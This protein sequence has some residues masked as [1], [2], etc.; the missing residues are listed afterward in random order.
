[1]SKQNTLIIRI[2]DQKTIDRVVHQILRP[3]LMEIFES[4]NTLDGSLLYQRTIEMDEDDH[5]IIYIG[6]EVVLDYREYESSTHSYLLKVKWLQ[7]KHTEEPPFD[8]YLIQTVLA[9]VVSACTTQ[10]SDTPNI[11]VGD[12]QRLMV[13]QELMEAQFGSDGYTPSQNGERAVVKVGDKTGHVDLNTLK[14]LECDSSLL[15]GRLEG[16]LRVAEQLARPLIG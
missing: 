3:R 16:V 1:M 5:R 7:Q 6:N 2:E 13:I 4:T 14:V 8:L 10:H 9:I 12:Q 15:K 11:A